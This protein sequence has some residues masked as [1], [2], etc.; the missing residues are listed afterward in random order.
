MVCLIS[1][2]S[3]MKSTL[4]LLCLIM[5]VFAEDE[6]S[7]VEPTDASTK[8]PETS[9]GCDP[10]PSNVRTLRECCDLPSQSNVML[11]NV[12]ST[13]CMLKS[14]DLQADCAVECYVNMTRL[15]INGAIAKPV[16]KRIYDSNSYY[17]RSWKKVISDGVDKC[18]YVAGETLTQG[19]V[20]FYNCVNDYMSE[21][22]A[23]FIQTAECEATENQFEKCKK[24]Q[25][26]CSSW[27]NNLMHPDVCC[28]T[29]KLFND[30]LERKC[31]VDC[32]RKEFFVTKQ[33]QCINNCTWVETGLRVDG[34]VDFE[35]VK[36]MVLES[37]KKN[38]AWE[39]PIESAMDVCEKV[40]R[41]V[42]AQKMSDL[43]INIHL[44]RCLEENLSDKCAEFRPEP[45]CAKVKRFVKQCPETKPHRSRMVYVSSTY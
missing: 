41:G 17:E 34:K 28:L 4:I 30:D 10:W 9:D 45:Y 43:S 29:P 24:V 8:A 32:N 31:R 11:Q 37:S 16:V 25:A 33:A 44:L 20:K 39:K 21:N 15:I 35:V 22:C 23:N 18:E 27:P 5:A 6:P 1:R 12:C 19:L 2:I 38:E 26:N 42:E 3:A 40:V 7:E 14:S 36:K 13:K